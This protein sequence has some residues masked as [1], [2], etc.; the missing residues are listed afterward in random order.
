MVP[1]PLPLPVALR[2]PLVFPPASPLSTPYLRHAADAC[3]DY[4]PPSP[5]LRGPAPR[6]T[7]GVVTAENGGGKDPT[8]KCPSSP[9][10]QPQPPLPTCLRVVVMGC[11]KLTLAS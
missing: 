11:L 9:C 6:A 5:P 7:V 3:Q 8:L 2:F 10:L 4:P 1:G